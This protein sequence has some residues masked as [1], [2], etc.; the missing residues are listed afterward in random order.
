MKLYVFGGSNEN[1][2]WYFTECRLSKPKFIWDIE[3]G[4][5]RCVL[6]A[7][8]VKYSGLYHTYFLAQLFTLPF[9]H[10]LYFDEQ[11][12]KKRQSLNWHRKE[13]FSNV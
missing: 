11:K 13:G 3:T 2:D 4:R 1:P 10:R 5:F 12:A 6:R 9:K 7:D 8:S